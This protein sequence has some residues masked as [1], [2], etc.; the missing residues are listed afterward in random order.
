MCCDPR[1]NVRHMA[2]SYLQRALLAHDLQ[3][4]SPNEWEACFLEV[5]GPTGESG[6]MWEGSSVHWW[7]VGSVCRWWWGVGYVGGWLGCMEGWWCVWEGDGMCG[8]VVG[9][10]QWVV[11]CVG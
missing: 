10:C 3:R 4:L 8:R 11:G 2:I 5:R 6:D 9:M 7:V 1:R